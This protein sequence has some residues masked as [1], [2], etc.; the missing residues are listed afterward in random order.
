MTF[1]EFFAHPL[2]MF[3]AAMLVAEL[4]MRGAGQT[5]AVQVDADML[6]RL[7]TVESWQRDHNS[8]HGCVTRLS[9]LMEGHT[10]QMRDMGR[11]VHEMLRWMMELR[12]SSLPP[13][14][15]TPRYARSP[16][17]FQ[18]PRDW[19]DRPEYAEESPRG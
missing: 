5:K 13:A 8:I 18:P 14:Q 1:E 4:R 15:V 19:V 17:D 7:K 2:V 16:Y 3:I 12:A 6:A 11:D 10:R 9:T